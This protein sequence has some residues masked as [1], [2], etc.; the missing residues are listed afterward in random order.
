MD[1]LRQLYQQTSRLW[2]ALNVQQRFFLVLCFGG[3]FAGLLYLIVFQTTPR[4]GTLFS[5]LQQSDAGEIAAKLKEGGIPF[6]P[7][8]DGSSIS[9]PAARVAETRLL[10]AQEGLPRGGG[11]GYEIFN[12]SRLG[13]TSFEQKIN[14]KRAIEGELARTINQLKEVR[15]SRVQIAMPEERL[16]TDQ[17]Q[18]PSASVFLELAIADSLDRRQIKSIQHLVASSVEGLNPGNVTILDQYANL[19]A[20]PTEPSMAPSEMSATQFEMRSRVEKYYHDKLKSMF[21]RILGPGNSVVSVS[22]ELDFDQIERTEEKFDPDS[23]AVRSEQ[24]QKEKTMLPAGAGGVAGIS[25]N[26]P[27][28]ASLSA[29]RG[30]LREASFAITN[31]EISRTVDHIIK[32]Q[33]SIKSISVAVV[34]DGT[35]NRISKPDGITTVEY[36][37]RSDDELDKYRRMVLAAVGEPAVKNVEVINVPLST[38]AVEKEREIAVAAQREQTRDLY[39]SIAKTAITIVALLL[40]FFLVRSLVKRIIPAL[41]PVL[42]KDEIGGHVDLVSGGEIDLTTDVKE[43]VENKPDEAAS[44]LKV[45]LKE[46]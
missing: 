33:S 4:Y 22:I 7:S 2:N 25:S 43:L 12:Q 6:T 1:F 34:V 3:V 28:V 26:L 46:Q 42:H 37:P 38:A 36:V 44:L 30:P 13:I 23:V 31:Y 8:D 29:Q 14:L 21:D 24:R 9:V 39:F 11:V 41:P 20:M 32:S 27:E 19:L 5:N 10:L 17:Q 16:Y 40:L 35:N 15:W 45:W 18:Q